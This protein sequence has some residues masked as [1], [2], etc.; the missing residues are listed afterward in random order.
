MS[1]YLRRRLTFLVAILVVVAGLLALRLIH[2]QIVRGADL[3]RQ[4][5]MERI[6]RLVLPEP[7]W[8][9][10]YDRDGFMLVANEPRYMIEANPPYIDAE[11]VDFV[12]ER[13]APILHVPSETISMVLSQEVSWV[14]L[15]PFATM[16]EGEAV[17]RLGL[18]GLDAR[19]RWVRRYP[20][21]ALAAH[22]LGF[23]SRGGGGFYGLEGYYDRVLRPEVPVWQGETGPTGRW[24]LPQEDGAVPPPLSGNDLVLTL[25]LAVQAVVEEEL[26][27]A[28][29]EFGAESGTVKI[30]RA[31]V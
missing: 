16:Q 4:A 22:V 14:S 19:L 24:P 18:D 26:A 29:E 15:E 25:D 1:A 3:R 27:R 7:S 2:V 21:G 11:D 30:G 13:L 17:Q 5:R 28:L 8:G 12:A 31:H 6:H 23:V 9:L 20:H 10:I